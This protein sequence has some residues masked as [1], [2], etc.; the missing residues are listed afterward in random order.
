MKNVAA[1]RALVVWLVLASGAGAQSAAPSTSPAVPA[2]SPSGGLHVNGI[3]GYA[4]PVP[5]GWTVTSTP[6]SDIV[7]VSHDK[8]SIT[9]YAK[10]KGKYDRFSV[11][12]VHRRYA[13]EHLWVDDAPSTQTE[14]KKAKVRSWE[15]EV[16]TSQYFDLDEIRHNMHHKTVGLSRNDTKGEWYLWLTTSYKAAT[17]DRVL[18]VFR[19]LLSG[20]EMDVA[21]T[22][23]AAE[24][25]R[26]FANQKLLLPAIH[27]WLQS[28][29]P[30]SYELDAKGVGEL[31]AA[32]PAPGFSL[33]DPG[34][35]QEAKY[36]WRR[37]PRFLMCERHGCWDGAIK[38]LRRDP[39]AS[40][41]AIAA[42]DLYDAFRRC[43][44]GQ[45]EL[46]SAFK[47]H[48]GETGQAL[49][50]AVLTPQL[51]D[52]LVNKHIGRGN[53]VD[54]P[55][56]FK[57]GSL[58]ASDSQAGFSCAVHGDVFG[59]VKGAAALPPSGITD[60]FWPRK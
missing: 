2:A 5:A 52:Q 55:H 14:V 50:I 8:H 37:A 39:G 45:K 51:F 30:T 25:Q 54:G 36:H 16:A 18:P 56:G 34:D 19:R 33:T 9:L 47:L 40:P 42:Q 58:R 29:P 6:K 46:S 49:T 48:Q 7:T 20:L 23:A 28:H 59:D 21:S 22:D 13:L 26:C 53:P 27:A 31:T 4:F 17:A 15:A 38:G 11:L 12:D 41:E 35:G 1:I 44:E 43:L 32:V 57:D 3:F 24:F 10:W 60:L